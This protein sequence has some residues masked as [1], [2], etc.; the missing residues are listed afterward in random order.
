MSHS[1]TLRRDIEAALVRELQARGVTSWTFEYHKR[2]GWLIFDWNGGVVTKRIAGS[3]SCPAA[4]VI[5]LQDL[6][7][8]MGVK[9]MKVAKNPDRKPR[10]RIERVPR[11]PESITILPDPWAPL[12]RL[13]T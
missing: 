5:A 10:V 4:V 7:R 6:R 13:I 11:L 8:L 2:H 1:M 3:P 12:R 9:R